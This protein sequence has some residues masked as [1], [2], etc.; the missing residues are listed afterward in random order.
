MSTCIRFVL[1]LAMGSVGVAALVGQDAARPKA[2]V[3]LRWV[4][5]KKIEGVTVDQGVQASCFPGD[6]G[7]PHQKPA[8][9]LTAADVAEAPLTTIKFTGTGQG[10]HYLVTLHLTKNARDRLAANCKGL[11]TRALIVVV[12][13][14]YWGIHRYEKDQDKPGI[15]DQARAESFVPTV[16]YFSSRAEAD[17]LLDALE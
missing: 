11:E 6:I 17:R 10:E 14:K 7:Y 5:C 2:R 1:A 12:D 3:E 4:E 13:G 8:L 9:V 16:G 15:P